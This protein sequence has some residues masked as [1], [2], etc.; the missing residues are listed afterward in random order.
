M[1]ASSVA[2]P[3]TAPTYERVNGSPWLSAGVVGL[4]FAAIGFLM[5]LSAGNVVVLWYL[6]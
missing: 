5:Y 4:V 2:T 1:T 6:Q 3:S